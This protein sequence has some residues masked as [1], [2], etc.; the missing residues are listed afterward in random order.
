MNF[1][2]SFLINWCICRLVRGSLRVKFSTVIASDYSF[3]LNSSNIYYG[4]LIASW[5]TKCV[6]RLSSPIFFFFHFFS[7]LSQPSTTPVKTR[8]LL[9]WRDD[10]K[11]S[12]DFFKA[13]SIFLSRQ[14][15][16]VS[17]PSS[18]RDAQLDHKT[19]SGFT[20]EINSQ[21]GL[22][23]HRRG[24]SDGGFSHFSSLHEWFV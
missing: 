2:C 9:K 13:P 8:K 10:E 6:T 16:G 15:L 19:T 5:Q 3:Y 7:F 14:F 12:K 17:W 18:G 1:R 21:R 20:W 4:S 24:P 22:L 11:Q 23:V